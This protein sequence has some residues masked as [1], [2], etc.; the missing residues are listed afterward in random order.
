MGPCDWW[1]GSANQNK[2]LSSLCL[3][4]PGLPRVCR[5][6]GG[7]GYRPGARGRRGLLRLTKAPTR[8]APLFWETL[9]TRERQGYLAPPEEPRKLQMKLH[10]E[11]GP[12]GFCFP[13]EVSLQDW[14]FWGGKLVCV[15][16]RENIRN[17]SLS[18]APG[19]AETLAH[20][21]Y[22]PGN[23]LLNQGLLTAGYH[24]LPPS[25]LLP[26]PPPRPSP[27]LPILSSNS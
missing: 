9:G 24:V 4:S 12:Q 22:H 3:A 13:A 8:S 15:I 23:P 21:Y 17:P 1:V 16:R 6:Q 7:M 19:L 10:A 14:L 20:I 11:N 25:G 2:P 26:P 27:R 5:G 18:K